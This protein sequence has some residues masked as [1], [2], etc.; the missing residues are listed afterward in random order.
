[1]TPRE[2]KGNWIGFQDLD[3][4][5]EFEWTD[6][7]PVLYAHWGKDSPVRHAGDNLACTYLNNNG[8]WVLSNC[9]DTRG[10]IQYSLEKYLKKYHKKGHEKCHKSTVKKPF[11]STVKTFPIQ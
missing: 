5:L 9:D 3:Q 6:G 7:T 1:M 11:S 10:A 8:L 2:S 4:D